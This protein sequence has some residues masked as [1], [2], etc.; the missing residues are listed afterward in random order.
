[1]Y[2]IKLLAPPA[3]KVTPLYTNRTKPQARRSR[4]S[5]PATPSMVQRSRQT[6]ISSILLA[7][8]L[9]SRHRRSTCSVERWRCVCV[10]R[11]PW[12]V[13]CVALKRNTARRLGGSR[14]LRRGAGGAA[15][16][17]W[18]ARRATAPRP[19]HG[20]RP[21]VRRDPRIQLYAGARAPGGAPTPMGR[22]GVVPRL[23]GLRLFTLVV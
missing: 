20:P 11:G 5:A 19:R 10:A 22:P 7:Q 14:H 21:R 6:P 17:A 1:M 12:C 18:R 13:V 16:G 9:N 4:T 3:T 23:V 8:H 15:G 2:I